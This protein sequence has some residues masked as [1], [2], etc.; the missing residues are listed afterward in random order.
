MVKVERRQRKRCGRSA[1]GG[2]WFF[3]LKGSKLPL[4]VIGD[5]AISERLQC[6]YPHTP[7]HPVSSE[8]NKGKEKKTLSFSCM[9]K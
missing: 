3:T 7:L 1:K 4:L 9:H 2:E 6:P 5:S 8:P